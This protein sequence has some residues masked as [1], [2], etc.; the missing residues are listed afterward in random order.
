M[1][2]DREY[3]THNVNHKNMMVMWRYLKDFAKKR[4][5]KE[6]DINIFEMLNLPFPQTHSSALQYYTDKNQWST[7]DTYARCYLKVKEITGDPNIYRNCGWIA[8]KYR[9]LFTY[10]QIIRAIGGVEDALNYSPLSILEWQN[11]KTLEVIIPAKYDSAADK[12]KATFKYKY[13]PHIDSCDSYC[14]DYHLLGML[15]ALPANFPASYFKPWVFLPLGE[16][17]MI[18]VQ[19]DPIK[20]YSGR[21]FEHLNLA[22]HYEGN[23]LYIRDPNINKIKNIGEKVILISSELDGKMVY[24]GKHEPSE[25]KPSDGKLL[26][27][28]I[29]ETISFKNELI[30]EAGV[31]MAAPYFIFNYQCQAIKGAKNIGESIRYFFS[32]KKTLWE[33]MSKINTNYQLEIEEKN[34]A[35]NDLKYYSDNLESI[36]QKRTEELRNKSEYIRQLDQI[37]MRVVSHGLGN[38]SANAIA[39]AN[40]VKKTI[41]DAKTNEYLSRLITNCGIAALASIGLNYYCK[42]NIKITLNE[43]ADFLNQRAHLSPILDFHMDEDVASILV[44]GR[45]YMILSE[46]FQNAIKAQ[47]NQ[48][49]AD[50]LVMRIGL[51]TSARYVKVVLT[52]RGKLYGDISILKS[53]SD[54]YP[55]SHQ[56]GWIC[57]RLAKELGGKITWREEEDSVK[58]ILELPVL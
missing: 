41:K 29:T 58:V 27:T 28:L 5:L 9:S 6:K 45:V 36:V 10:Q 35:Y 4:G 20:L 48:G 31:I 50:R 40:L 19:H 38:W 16:A 55:N 30:C 23:K 26:G 13:H 44:D 33:E 7:V 8:A 43:I 56:G 39:D 34:K 37:I 51:D 57:R 15:E 11:T 49:Y 54:D 25:G 46:I 14:S 52:N 32:S 47:I 2:K 53:D 12:I 18:M 1:I 22:P 21:F 24:L 42:N 3:K 17:R